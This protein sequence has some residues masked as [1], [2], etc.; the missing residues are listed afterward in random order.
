LERGG[1]KPA[2]HIGFTQLSP[3]GELSEGDRGEVERGVVLVL[4]RTGD[5]GQ[6]AVDRGVQERGAPVAGGECDRNGALRGEW[7]GA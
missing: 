6:L 1:E 3:G 7:R 2:G 4:A 5:A